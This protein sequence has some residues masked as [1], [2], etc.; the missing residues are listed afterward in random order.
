MLPV[1]TDIY[2]EPEASPDALA[3]LSHRGRVAVPVD[4]LDEELPALLLSRREHRLGLH[5]ALHG[6]PPGR[7][8]SNVCSF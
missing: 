4:V 5:L 8:G 6:A 2:A 1:P 7:G 3:N